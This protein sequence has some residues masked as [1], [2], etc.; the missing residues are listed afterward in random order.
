MLRF[1]LR[2]SSWVLPL[3]LEAFFKFHY[4]KVAEQTRFGVAAQLELLDK[5]GIPHPACSELARRL[6]PIA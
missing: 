6:P 3:D 5:A 2:W 4:T 1:A